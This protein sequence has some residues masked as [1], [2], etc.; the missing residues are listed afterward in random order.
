MTVGVSTGPP[1]YHAWTT[2]KG[3]VFNPTVCNSTN[4]Y[5][6]NAIDHAVMM[7]RVLF[8]TVNIVCCNNLNV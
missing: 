1:A 3:G 2:Y 5:C 6:A 4:K 7:R 8:A